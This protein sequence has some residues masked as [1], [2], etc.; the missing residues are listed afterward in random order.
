VLE[1]GWN[2]LSE[3]LAYEFGLEH[4]ILAFWHP[5]HL[6]LVKKGFLTSFGTLVL[7]PVDMEY[8]EL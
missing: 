3:R 2:K 5:V 4:T 6:P 1:V 8:K 7:Y